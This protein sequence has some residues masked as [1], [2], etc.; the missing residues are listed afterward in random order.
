[1]YFGPNV[2]TVP[3]ISCEILHE[4]AQNV[5]NLDVEV[6]FDLE[7]QGQSTPNL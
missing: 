6:K 7:G 3:R 4:Q 1:M 2:E 5:V